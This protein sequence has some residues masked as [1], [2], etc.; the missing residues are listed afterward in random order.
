MKNESDKKIGK[1]TQVRFGT[2]GYQD[3]AF[4]LS[5]TFESKKGAWS[6]SAFV[7]GG[8]M[9]GVIDPDKSA[10]W[11]EQDRRKTMA[12]LCYK[13][14]E[15]LRAAEVNDISELVGKPVEVTFDSNMLKD[16]RIL[17]EAI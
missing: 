13:M 14:A 9:P 11:T 17:T 2:G 10:K 3:A 1:I 15:T 5:L 7:S 6:V 12:D 16:W 8:W 4:G